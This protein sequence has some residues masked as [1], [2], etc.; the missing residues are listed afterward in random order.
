MRSTQHGPARSLLATPE[1][2]DRAYDA[3]FSL[4]AFVMNRYLMDHLRRSARLLTEGDYEALVI[5]G[6]LAHQNVAHLMAPGSLP[7]AILNR[8]GRIPDD[9][10]RMRPLMLRDIAAITGIPRET[11][12]RKLN[13]LASQHYVTRDGRGWVISTERAEPELR[14]FT[15]ESTRRMLATAEEIDTILRSAIG[16]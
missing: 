7:G 16:S 14:E 12:R 13:W 4:V 6:V 1:E 3:T 10:Q 9:E 2:F 8:R 11:T 15:R 5:W